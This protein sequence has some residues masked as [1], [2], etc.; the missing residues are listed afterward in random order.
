MLYGVHGRCIRAEM[1]RSFVVGQRV[2]NFS[3]VLAC[4]Q[5]FFHSSV[6]PR[7][8]CG[9]VM[10]H[11]DHHDAARGMS[12]SGQCQHVANAKKMAMKST[13][14]LSILRTA[15]AVVM[16]FVTALATALT[17][18]VSATR[19]VQNFNVMPTGS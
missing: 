1:R 11:T 14:G 10:S 2:V 9:H 4:L 19:F 16:T 17:A 12:D 13:P 3:G 7:C 15:W 18:M 5:T 6:Q 8:A